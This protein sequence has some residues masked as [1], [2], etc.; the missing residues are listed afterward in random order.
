MRK[1]S[2]DAPQGSEAGHLQRRDLGTQ[3]RS[4]H[5][6]TT[7]TA[8][9]GLG[10]AGPSCSPNILGDPCSRQCISKD[11]PGPSVS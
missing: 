7:H 8:A 5:A 1:L 2:T 4:S 3:A 9:T 6:H 11:N 10:R